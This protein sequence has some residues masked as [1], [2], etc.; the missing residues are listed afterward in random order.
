MIKVRYILTI[1]INNLI[2]F[3]CY[4][5]TITEPVFVFTGVVMDKDSLAP[6]HQAHYFLNNSLGGLTDQEGRFAVNVRSGD[7]LRFTYV[8]YRDVIYTVPGELKEDDYLAGIF[9]SRDTVTLKRVVI[10]PR[11]RNLRMEMVTT[12]PEEDPAMENAIRNVRLSAY[13]GLVK[14]PREMDAEMNQDIVQQ[15]YIQRAYDRGLIPSDQYLPI[16]AVIPFTYAV[17]RALNNPREGPEIQLNPA[18]VDRIKKLYLQE[19]E[20]MKADTGV[21]RIR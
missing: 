2:I 8:G 11:I 12:R 6:L 19:V 4:S 14:V 5:Q 7:R 21:I 9:M 1:L 15:R 18:D 10:V 17:I 20:R 16:T 13:L 3:N